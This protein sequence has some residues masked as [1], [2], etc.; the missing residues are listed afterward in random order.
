MEFLKSKV[1]GIYYKLIQIRY[2]IWIKTHPTK[3]KSAKE[4]PIVINNFNRLEYLQKLIKSLEKR[5]YTNIHILDNK[6]TYQPLLDF[7]KVTTYPVYLLN[8]NLGFMALWKVP[9]L[10]NKFT[11]DYFV[12]T[13]PDLEI[14]NECPENFLDNIWDTM[15]TD[16]TISKI[17]LSLLINDIPNHYALKKEVI[18]FEKQYSE[19]VAIPGYYMANVDTTFALHRPL[20]KIGANS[21]L[22]MYRSMYPVSIRHLPWYVESNNLTEEEQYY[23]NKSTAVTTWASKMKENL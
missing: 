7:Y 5:G 10:K 1:R 23:V 12:Y 14:I 4:I 22:K 2:W 20:T 17:G 8:K 16:A 6:S 19:K 21:Y 9:K 15:K 3:F 18:E 13:D 11:R